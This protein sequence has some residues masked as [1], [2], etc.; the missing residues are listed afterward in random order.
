MYSNLEKEIKEYSDYNK[1]SIVTISKLSQFY[2]SIGQQGKKFIKS[3]LSSL[4]DFN[5][6]LSKENTS[7]TISITYNYF[8]FNLKKFLNIFEESLDNFEIKLGQ[9]IE[10]Y[11]TKFKNSYGEVINQFNTL[12]SKINE[13]KEKLEKSKYS[14]FDCCKNSLDV[15][16][17][18]IQ[19][20]DSKMILREDVSKLNAQLGKSMKSVEINEQSYKTEI[21][22]MNKLYND[23]E[24]KYKDII[25]KLRNINIEKIKFFSEVLK[26]FYNISTELLDKEQEVN[27]NLEKISE[28]IK[29]NRDIIL[30]DEKFYFFNDNKKRF[31]LEQ[32]LDFKKFKKNLEK[33]E[34]KKDKNNNEEEMKND[35]INKI[36]NLGK[37]DD[38]FIEKEEEAKADYLFLNYLLFNKEKIEEKDYYEKMEKLKLKEN[39]I[40]GFMSVLIT[41]YKLN[42]NV[43]IENHDN[44]IYLSKILDLILNIC[45]EKN[46]I[47]DICFMI[48]YVAE[49]T[50]Y[51]DKNNI[52]KKQYLC[53]LLSANKNF[54]DQQFWKNLIDR[55]IKISTNRKVK[56][57]IEMKEIKD[58]EEEKPT[59]VMSGFKNYFFSSK[60]KDNQKLENEILS[61]QLYEEKLPIYAVE[62]LEEYIHHF[63]NFNFMHKESS[64]IIV[65]LSSVY[66][67][68]N[69]YV[70]YFIAK[71]NSNLYSI[72]NKSLS[73]IEKNFE[74]NYEKLFFNTDKKLFKK[75]LDNKIRCLVYSLKFIDIKELPKLL[76]LNKTYNEALLKI[77]YKNILIKY[78]DMD[79]KTHIAIWKIILGYSKVKK[80]YFYKN[81]LEQVN[82]QPQNNAKDIITLD[83]KRT[84]F[85]KDKEI[86]RE[87]IGNILRCLS[88][89]CPEVNYSQGMNFIAA[90]LLNITGDEEEAFY[91]FLSLL[92]TSD[93]GNLF[94]KDLANLKSYF[95]VF[96]RI[97]DILLPELYNH[98]KINN[99]KV[100]FFISPWFITLF[101]DTYLNIKNR[102]NPKVLMRIWDLFLFSGCK[103]ILKV[104]ISLL[105]NFENKIMTL[106]FEELLKFLIGDL[107]TSEFFQ[108]EYYDNLMKTYFNFKIESELIS[109]IEN[110]Y[111]I[112]KELGGENI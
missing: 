81:V 44:F 74:L 80:E 89:C 47:F 72:K 90:F 86:N 64:D 58:K 70:T 56:Q 41:F 42:Q 39:N 8:S 38:S 109:N 52:Y 93:Y 82:N 53:E 59:G 96:E 69:K 71:L 67:F 102:E 73:K 54:Q 11:E 68:N 48:I 15:E 23:S 26:I 63:S 106:T 65:D 24:S 103:S 108:N 45:L 55:K 88:I 107:P 14:Y 29:V 50:L 51:S 77:V 1:Q 21:D 78:R 83:I 85:E 105:K 100:S 22:K 91:L 35:I 9:H 75:I 62:T 97:L 5:S 36:V 34:N 7:S 27:K 66:K 16:N 112:K 43:N 13:R 87:K 4:D 101:T 61:I 31:L 111:Q 3:I 30:Y 37:N 76:T 20:K 10:K 46:N 25:Q 19:Q 94:M 60:K 92:L 104:G 95:Y 18:I 98:L 6:E 79:L 40:I 12:S 2:K 49:K 99:I 17:K 32:F 28:N 57:E 110:E 84:Q 33:K